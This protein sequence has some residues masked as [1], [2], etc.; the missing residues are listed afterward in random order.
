MKRKKRNNKGQIAGQV[1]IYI[2][3][4]IVIG[5]IA[6]IGYNAINKIISKSCDAERANFKLDIEKDIETQT[7]DGSVWVEKIDV[8][9]GYDTICFAGTSMIGNPAFDCPNR[10]IRDSVRNGIQQNIFVMSGQDTIQLG[11]SEL[12]SL[13]S[14]HTDPLPSCICIKQRNSKFYITFSGRGSSTEISAS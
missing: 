9:C 1:F 2:M 8:P 3:A 6:L 7:S 12:I 11:Y 4:V 10:I 5:A 14:D 13:D